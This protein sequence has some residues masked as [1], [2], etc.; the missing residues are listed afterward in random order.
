MHAVSAKEDPMDRTRRIAIALFASLPLAAAAQA[1][2]S[3]IRSGEEIVEMQCVKC[4]AEGL[5][6]APRIGDRDAWLHRARKGF[7]ALLLGAIRGHGDMPARG[8]LAQLSDVETRA[9][10]MFMF[11]ASMGTQLAH[12]AASP[13]RSVYVRS[14]QDIVLWRCASCH[15]KGKSGAPRIAD[16]AAWSPRV[17]NGIPA[18]VQSALEGHARM[19]AGGGTVG[20]TEK[21]MSAATS[22]LTGNWTVGAR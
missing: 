7:D 18:L 20:L 8:G 17:K 6:G 19:P 12:G 3:R 1:W 22:Y 15:E 11:Q 16:G 10:I 13:P 21:E 9:A 5:H 2:D 4:H 14:P